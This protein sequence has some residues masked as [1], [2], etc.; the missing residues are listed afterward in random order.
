MIKIKSFIKWFLTAMIII[1]IVGLFVPTWTPSIGG[2]NSISELSQISI[3][4][5][6][7]QFMIRG[8][9]K[10][11]PIIIFVHGGP[12]CS[13]IPYVTKYQDILEKD[14][15][16]VHYDQRGS[17]KSYHFFED[18]SN[19][20]SQLLISD[21]L[22]ITDYISKR[23]DKRKILLVGHSFGTYIALQAAAQAPERFTAYIGIGQMSDPIKNE[24]NSLKYC[25]EQAHE[26]GNANDF[27]RLESLTGHIEKGN[28]IT[29]RNYIRK[30]GG[31][32]RLIDDN[33]DYLEGFLTHPEYNLLDVIRYF[34]GVSVSQDVLLAESTNNPLPSLVESIEI[35]CYFIMGQY[36]YMTTVESAK[37]YFDSIKAT[38]KEFIIY[39]NS[40]H[41]P[42]FEEKE[43]FAQWLTN[44]FSK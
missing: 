21:L 42:Q 23:F 34:R 20:T 38:E 16:I 17:G 25:L 14:F 26:A 41:Y 30:Y 12:G 39:S 5:A 22:A 43:K 4:G 2:E 31:A 8:K 9:N 15:T 27:T 35:P 3:N 24:L 33:G 40:A 11:N 32:S 13:E 6:E 7:H 18:Y 19:I 28:I 29:P 10:N 36:D 1:I 37:E 44:K